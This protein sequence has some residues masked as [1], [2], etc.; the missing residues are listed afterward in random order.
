[1]ARAPRCRRCPCEKFG[2]RDDERGRAQSRPRG[3]SSALAAGTRNRSSRCSR[4]ARHLPRSPPSRF[5]RARE[6]VGELNGGARAGT[7]VVVQPA[8]VISSASRC[9]G[10]GSVPGAN[11]RK[12]VAS[13]AMPSYSEGSVR[14]RRCPREPGDDCVSQR[15]A[16]R[17]S[18]ADVARSRPAP[19][20]SRRCLRRA[21]LGR[22][23][24]RSPPSRR[25][26]GRQPRAVVVGHM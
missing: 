20:P 3:V 6:D 26:P 4:R 11:S 9:N 18:R 15:P 12:A 1:M 7:R 21:S 22:P 2:P 24:G 14:V 23:P 8:G 10:T 19:A 5:R 25:T 13:P 16:R 17:P